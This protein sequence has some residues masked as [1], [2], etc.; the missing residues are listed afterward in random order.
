MFD[1]E[2]IKTIYSRMGNRIT[3]TRQVLQRPLTLSEKILYSHL[4]HNTKPM[5][6][7]GGRS[8][9]VPENDMHAFEA[10]KAFGRFQANL[11]DLGGSTLMETIPDFH[12][13]RKRFDR[14]KEVYLQDSLNRVCEVKEL[15]EY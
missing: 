14:F 9:D 1:I 12:N 13:T 11:N 7:E 4:G 10:A 5:D 15:V 3:Q 2:K 6:F 8:Y